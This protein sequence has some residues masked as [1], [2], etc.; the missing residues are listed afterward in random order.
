MILDH[1]ILSIITEVFLLRSQKT[2]KYFTYLILTLLVSSC[3]APVAENKLSEKELTQQCFLTALVPMRM[4]IDRNAGADKAALYVKYAVDSQNPDL[5]NFLQKEIDFVISERPTEPY[6]YATARYLKCMPFEKPSEKL[7][8]TRAC[9]V[10]SLINE[11]VIKLQSSGK[12]SEE[13]LI[14]V[15]EIFATD[16]L[17]YKL[18]RRAIYKWSSDD[19][20]SSTAFLYSE[21]SEC[22]A[23][24]TDKTQ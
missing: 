14:S 2:M 6:D 3:A 23:L 22:M 11:L 8:Q 24:E 12:T 9:F 19:K 13:T 16:S 20:A 15:G 4:A 7:T 18:A 17:Q 10:T 5:K 1:N 21:F